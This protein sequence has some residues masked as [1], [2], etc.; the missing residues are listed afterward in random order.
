M[1]L[2]NAGDW[3][4][5]HI[6]FQ[7]FVPVVRARFDPT[8]PPLNP[9]S[10]RQLGFRLSRF[11]FNN[12]ANPKYKPGAF[13]LEVRHLTSPQN[14]CTA[15]LNYTTEANTVSFKVCTVLKF[16]YFQQR[17]M[18]PCMQQEGINTSSVDAE[19]NKS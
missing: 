5:I 9:A 8:A 10:V 15:F 11:D 1:P 19:E 17:G 12:L 18:M 7:E 6:P 13:K 4:T 14:V 2:L 16:I 3:Q